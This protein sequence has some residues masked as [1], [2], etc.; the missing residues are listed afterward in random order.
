M[1]VMPVIVCRNEF[2]IKFSSVK[3]AAQHIGPRCQKFVVH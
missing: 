3:S 1:T 2:G